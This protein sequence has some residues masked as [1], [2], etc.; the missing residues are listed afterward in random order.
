LAAR[1]IANFHR[2]EITRE[3]KEGW[4]N[5]LAKIYKSQGLKTTCV[6][7]TGGYENQIK[8]RIMEVTGLDSSTVTTYLADE[9]KQEL[10]GGSH[11]MPAPQQIYL[12]PK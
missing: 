4:I 9:F 3:E 2:R 6:I 1:L 7:S 10:V 5:G 8:N 12:L 11:G